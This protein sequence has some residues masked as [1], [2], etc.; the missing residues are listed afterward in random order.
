MPSL[1]GVLFLFK[2]EPLHMDFCLSLLSFPS[3]EFPAC[4]LLSRV[5]FSQQS[6][7]SST[8]FPEG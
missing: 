8:F 2:E 4:F 1:M 3:S 6:F 7:L 5:A